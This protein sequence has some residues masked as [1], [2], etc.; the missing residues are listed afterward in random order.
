[1]PPDVYPH[2]L[3]NSARVIDRILSRALRLRWR[4]G[5]LYL[6]ERFTKSKILLTEM[7]VRYQIWVM[8][9]AG[10]VPIIV[11]WALHHENSRFKPRV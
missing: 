9:L 1:M 10:T 3:T 2:Q 11:S 8:N 4:L 6:P 7:A 5:L